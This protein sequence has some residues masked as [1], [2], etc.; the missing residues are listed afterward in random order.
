MAE[1]L[2]A[3]PSSPI[4]TEDPDNLIH[5]IDQAV[6]SDTLGLNNLPNYYLRQLLDT[7]DVKDLSNLC[8]ASKRIQNICLDHESVW[9][10]SLEHYFP[11]LKKENNISWREAYIRAVKNQVD[12]PVF[13]NNEFAGNLLGSKLT[14]KL[15]LYTKYIPDLVRK[16]FILEGT[17]VIFYLDENNIYMGISFLVDG[18]NIRYDAMLIPEILQLAQTHGFQFN[19]DPEPYLTIYETRTAQKVPYSILIVDDSNIVNI[20]RLLVTLAALVL[21]D[22]NAE[23]IPIP[24]PLPDDPNAILSLEN[25]YNILLLNIIEFT[26]RYEQVMQSPVPV[27]YNQHYL[28]NFL[29]MTALGK[30]DTHPNALRVPEFIIN[31]HFLPLPETWLVLYLSKDNFYL[32]HS[33]SFDG[34]IVPYRRFYVPELLQFVQSKKPNV[35]LSDKNQNRL[36]ILNSGLDKPPD[37]IV[38]TNNP[39][40]IYLTRVILTYL[41]IALENAHTNDIDI[42][43]QPPNAPK[44]YKEITSITGA[45]L[46]YIFLIADKVNRLGIPIEPQSSSSYFDPR[47]LD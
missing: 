24:F 37:K 17:W 9:K 31:D 34:K 30:I 1:V 14:E 36:I 32:A 3:L 21:Q 29:R 7:T 39:E 23:N 46:W 33:Y 38:V 10:R 40:L 28:G 27:Y 5:S 13:C 47:V 22:R 43:I 44:G 35:S 20:S 12:I 45:A 16:K 26:G 2:S 19:R 25:V 11:Y 4:T 15:P 41:N 8:R 18:N 6:I 42:V